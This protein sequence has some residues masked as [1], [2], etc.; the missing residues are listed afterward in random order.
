[1]N[2]YTNI[3]KA[4]TFLGMAKKEGVQPNYEDFGIIK[5]ASMVL[6]KKGFVVWVGKA[7]D[8]NKKTF[9]ISKVYDLNNQNIYPS[10]TESHTHL[11]YGGNRKKEFELKING[12]TYME[13][14]NQG[15][16]IS[17]TVR[18]TKKE[19]FADLK[20]SAQKRVD[21][22]KKQGV[23]LLEIKSGYGQDLKTEMKQLKV[24]ADLKGVK[25]TPTYLGLHSFKG[26]KEEYVK[27]VLGND[28][29]KVVKNFPKV[30]RADLF[31]EKGFF[32]LKDLTAYVNLLKQYG[33]DFCAHVDQLSDAG[34]AL[35]AAKLGA[36]SIEH[37]VHLKTSEIKKIKNYKTVVNLLPA[38][39]FY[40]NT[41]YP[42]ARD[43]I[44]NGVRVSLATDFNP[45]SSPTQ[46]L[47]FVG[48]LARRV[49][50]MSLP[51]V[52]CSYTLNASRALGV[53]NKGALLKGWVGDFI[54]T[55]KE[56]DDFFYDSLNDFDLKTFNKTTKV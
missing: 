54:Q 45:G 20:K 5:N 49:M 47:N 35:A 38:A 6:D 30:K 48:L 12:A 31:I 37:A 4:Y 55:E 8:L 26:D 41:D 10:F 14:Q 22:F 16:G 50:K 15:G 51:E 7:K 9:E 3:N 53:Y 27:R 52:F 39:D 46:N 36:L 18:D 29:L 32:S 40:L 44:D 23:T 13:I 56:P 17:K 11:V 42:K 25:I 34:G 24:I 43:L 28:F 21:L 19:G 1:M 33:F 2:L